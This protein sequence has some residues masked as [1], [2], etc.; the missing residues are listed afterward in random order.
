MKAAILDENNRLQAVL[1]VQA[2]SP[3]D[4][5]GPGN[6]HLVLIDDS[7]VKDIVSSYSNYIWTGER[8]ELSPEEYVLIESDMDAASQMA[9]ASSIPP[10]TPLTVEATVVE[11]V[12]TDDGEDS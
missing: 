12:T 9:A 3:L 2:G 4:W 5:E 11:E 1:D 6:F 8:F 7:M 10:L